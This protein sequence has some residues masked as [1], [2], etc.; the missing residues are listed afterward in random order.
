METHDESIGLEVCTN[1]VKGG[2]QYSLMVLFVLVATSRSEA[3]NMVIKYLQKSSILL[4]EVVVNLEE[5]QFCWRT[6][7]IEEDTLG[8]WVP[9]Q[10]VPDKKLL[11][12]AEYVYTQ[13]VYRYF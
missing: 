10:V 6:K 5:I 1:T 4:Y 13:H 11:T 8:I 12:H 9:G 7:E 3:T 2:H